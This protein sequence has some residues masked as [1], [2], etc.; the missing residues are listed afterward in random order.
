MVFRRISPD[1]KRA[2]IRIY[3]NNLM[4][5][6][7]I[8]DCLDMSESTFFRALQLY[9]ETGDV[10]KPKSTTRGRPRKLHF[11]DLTY[12]TALINHR[13][14]WFLDE[15]LGLLDT[16]RFIS[17]HFTTIYRELER[18]GVSL[19]KLRRIAKERDED[20]RA[21]FVR[22]MGQYQPEQIGFLDEFSK[23]ERTLHRRRL[24]SLDGVVAST[25]VEGSMTREKYL[26]F[27][28]HS[29][30]SSVSTPYASYIT[31]SRKVEC[32]GDGQCTHSPWV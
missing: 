14:D 26:Y 18:S 29:V 32:A 19:K 7:D 21:D 16:N 8:L 25:V 23:D 1:V 5:L 20:L 13:P 4:D 10:E 17:V 28:E 30:V 31:I 12:M 27:L 2:A 6:D 11:D 15:L 22:M 24:L 9:R 3:E